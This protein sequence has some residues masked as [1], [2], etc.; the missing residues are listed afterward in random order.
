MTLQSMINLG[1]HSCIMLNLCMDQS[2]MPKPFR[3]IKALQRCTSLL[4]V[5]Q[6]VLAR[7]TDGGSPYVDLRHQ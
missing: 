5:L 2:I 1:D 6:E 4:L 7:L 3:Y